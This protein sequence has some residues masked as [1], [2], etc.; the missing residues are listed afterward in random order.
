MTRVHEFSGL[1]REGRTSVRGDSQDYE[2]TN[3]TP[4]VQVSV[5]FPEGDVDEARKA[6]QSIVSQLDTYCTYSVEQP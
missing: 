2:S 5:I 3:I 4:T 1:H 6:L